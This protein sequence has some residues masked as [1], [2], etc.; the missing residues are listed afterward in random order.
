[1]N[2]GGY[3]YDMERLGLAEG[4]KG[5]GGLRRSLIIQDAMSVIEDN[6]YDDVNLDQV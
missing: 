4:P 2:E 6:N 3:V 1:M 5:D